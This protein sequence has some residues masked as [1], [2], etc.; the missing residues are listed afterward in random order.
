LNKAKKTSSR[1]GGIKV[2]MLWEVKVV[3]NLAGFLLEVPTL[4]VTGQGKMNIPYY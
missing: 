3:P 1:R 2:Y 4:P